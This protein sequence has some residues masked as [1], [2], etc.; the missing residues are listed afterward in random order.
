MN[1][2][3]VSKAHPAVVPPVVDSDTGELSEAVD[4]VKA[5]IVQ[6][7]VGPLLGIGRKILYGLAGALMMGVGL[8]F[9]SLGLLRLVQDRAP[10]LATG[11]LSWIAY[12]IVVVFSAL[13]SA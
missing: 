11:S 5:Y 1:K 9:L 3:V 2:P 7:T 6:E 8:L 12:V 10:R 13:V 4:L